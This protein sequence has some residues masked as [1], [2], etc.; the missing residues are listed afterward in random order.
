MYDCIFKNRFILLVLI[1]SFSVSEGKTQSITDSAINM[2]IRESSVKNSILSHVVRIKNRSVTPF[3]GLIKLETLQEIRLL[4][5]NERVIEVAPGDSVFVSFKMIVEENI[6]AGKEKIQYDIFNEKKEKI[7]SKEVFINI[8]KRVQ[9]Q[10]LTDNIPQIIIHPQDSVRI[11]VTVN[12]NG[13]THENVTLVFNVPGLRGR[14]AFSELKAIIAPKE[15]KQFTYSFMP[16]SN[17]LS[18]G[19]FPVIITSMNGD[20]KTL[21]G[22]RTIIVQNI[23]SDRNFVDTNPSHSLLSNYGSD[24]NSLSISYHQYNSSS[25]ILNLRGGSVLNLPAGYLQLKGEMY[26]YNSENVPIVSNTSLVYKLDENEFMLGNINEM[27]ELSLFGRGAKV[28]LSDDKRS[29]TLTFG[30]IDQNFNL[31]SLQPL[32]SDY[33]SFYMKGTLGQTNTQKGVM[34]AI[35][36]YQ[37]NPYEKAIYN[38][39]GLQ[40]GIVLK[41]DWKIKLAVHGSLGSYE[42]LPDSKLSGSAEMTYRGKISSSLTLD[43][44]A[45]YSDSYFPGNRKGTLFFSQGISQKITND[46]HINWNFNF[47]KSAPK[48]YINN[49]TYQSETHYGNVTITLPKLSKLLSSFYYQYQNENTPSYTARIGT[50]SISENLRM[51]SNRLG[52]QWS[53][54]SPDSKHSLYGTLEGGFFSNP[55]ETGRGFQG[56]ST[57]NYSYHWLTVDASYQ[58][59]AYYLYEYMMSKQSNEEFKRFTAAASINKNISNKISLISNMNFSWDTYQGNVPSVNLTAKYILKDNLAFF[60]NGYWSQ[61]KFITNTTNILNAEVGFTYNFGNVQPQ[62]GRKSTINAQLYYDN[63][64]NSIYD[65]GDEAASNYLLSISGKTFIADEK[66]KIRYKLVPYG[67]YTIKPIQAGRW[68]FDQKKIQVNRSKVTIEIPLK[69]SGTLQGKIQYVIGKHSLGIPRYKGIRFTITNSDKSVSYT[70]ITDN[71]GKIIT[72]LPV[73]E[74]SITLDKKT[75]AEHTDCKDPNRTFRIEA[76]NTTI[77]DAFYIE[78]Q[79][80]QVNVK[81]F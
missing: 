80:R 28:I 72:F 19:Q 46:I 26:K 48:S 3:K 49:Y 45:Y 60:I 31:L 34:Q 23:F 63:N 12:N 68:F 40:W 70:A 2:S 35:Y 42:N 4:S 57:L 66:G 20:E 47:N 75:L 71:D 69:Q 9:L 74:Y 59:G 1:T 55:S 73:G 22:N 52:W 54:Q 17:L 50:D 79:S 13:N 30:A 11:N 64:A 76:R 14:P 38:V 25:N 36:I 65:E 24:N 8:E 18:L 44:S 37:K 5:Q 39:V 29:K 16:S 61:Y 33:Y 15:N 53:W 62:S 32:F 51:S 10:L 7:L 21:F 43:G 81:R 27:A 78:T 56:K 41:P 6:E 67:K 58:K 77:L